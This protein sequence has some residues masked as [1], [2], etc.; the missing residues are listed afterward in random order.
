MKSS[1]QA[2][3][4]SAFDGAGVGP[5]GAQRDDA[6]GAVEGDH[7]GREAIERH[8]G[9]GGP[10]QLGAVV[11]HDEVVL[12]VE[13]HGVHVGGV[14]LVHVEGLAVGPALALELVVGVQVDAL[15][16]VVDIVPLGGDLVGGVDVVP[17]AEAAVDAVGVS[18]GEG[19]LED[20][21]DVEPLLGRRGLDVADHAPGG[22]R[23]DHRGDA[24]HDHAH[25]APAGAVAVEAGAV[26]VGRGGQRGTPLVAVLVAGGAVVDR[27]ALGEVDVLVGHREAGADGAGGAV[28]H[29]SAGVVGIGRCSRSRRRRCRRRRR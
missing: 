8:V 17:V 15:G 18:E 3:S 22:A 4:R 1:T 16:D 7:V 14:A 11:A 24:A 5:V 13:P 25:L 23:A 26:G 6:A 29:G 9:A 28:G 20:R 27:R 19:R 2:S 12:A 10:H 21:V